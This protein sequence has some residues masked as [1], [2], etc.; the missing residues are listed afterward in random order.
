M[1]KSKKI[2]V[3]LS[4]LA[5]AGGIVIIPSEYTY[6]AEIVVSNQAE[7]DALPEKEEWSGSA[8]L[9]LN[10]SPSNN[11]IK[12]IGIKT[13]KD[14]N[15]GRA[16]E[17]QGVQNAQNNTLILTDCIIFKEDTDKGTGQVFGGYAQNGSAINNTVIINGSS[18]IYY[19]VYGGDS[20]SGGDAIGNTVIIAG[21]AKIYGEDIP[22]GANN[23]YIYGGFSYIGGQ[24]GGRVEDNTV[25]IRDNADISNTKIYGGF[26]SVDPNIKPDDITKKDFLK[27]NNSVIFD[28]WSGSVKAVRS[29]D[30]VNF[31]NM[32]LSDFV[33]NT[34]NPILEITGTTEDDSFEN[35]IGTDNKELGTKNINIG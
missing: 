10:N 22:N 2:G 9:Y 33:N 12:F 11:T 8:S 23:Q 34:K 35:I 18:E 30:N 26:T 17:A 14:I 28:D 32:N 31:H 21:D 25:I 20:V 7:F 4:V 16:L 29:C 3:A 15:G 5:I 27:N 19:G 13:S 1:K 24:T 6:A